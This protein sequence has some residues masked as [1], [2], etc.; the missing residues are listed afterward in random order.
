MTIQHLGDIGINF[1]DARN[2]LHE[3]P[4]FGSERLM[5]LDWLADFDVGNWKE[6]VDGK[7]DSKVNVR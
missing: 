7:D 5:T 4:L 6:Y 2:T 3:K 1:A